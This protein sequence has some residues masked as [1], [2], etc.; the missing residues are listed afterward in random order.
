M[1]ISLQEQP[2]FLLK[3]A[4]LPAFV[5]SHV[6]DA[7]FPFTR[8]KKMLPKTRG[9]QIT[10]LTDDL[11][12]GHTSCSRVLLRSFRYQLYM[13]MCENVAASSRKRA[14]THHRMYRPTCHHCV[15][16]NARLGDVNGQM[17]MRLYSFARINA[18][19]STPHCNWLHDTS[20]SVNLLLCSDDGVRW[21]CPSRTHRSFI[22]TRASTA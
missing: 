4:S 8:V 6:H 12:I 11:K 21:A 22:Q 18:S 16:T 13:T 9:R 14:P 1:A 7:N 19:T 15:P 10:P 5:V 3:R 20:C 2:S 17:S